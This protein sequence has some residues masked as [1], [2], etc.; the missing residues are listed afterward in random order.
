MVE[1]PRKKKERETKNIVR[2]EEKKRQA[3]ER[4]A[5]KADAEKNK[6]N[7]CTTTKRPVRSS[8]ASNSKWQKICEDECD[9]VGLQHR[10]I[11]ES[12][13][14]VC[15][16]HWEEDDA[17]E[18]L[19]CTN[20]NVVCGAMQIALKKATK[21]MFSSCVKLV[22]CNVDKLV[23]IIILTRMFSYLQLLLFVACIIS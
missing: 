6:K 3:L 21:H 13:C 1:K 14:A 4:E 8:D 5:K 7:K 9:E 17:D 20:E 12:E 15:F 11:S 10:E 2:E 18:W 23:T 22:F 19:M 16:S